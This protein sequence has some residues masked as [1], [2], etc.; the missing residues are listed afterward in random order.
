MGTSR[1]LFITVEVAAMALAAQ[2]CFAQGRV[3]EFLTVKNWHG[4]VNIK[5]SGTGSSS[6]GIFSD[7][8]DYGITTTIDLQLDTYNAN[9]E[10]WTGTFKGNSAINAKDVAT[11][12]GCKQTSTQI[13]QGTFG[14]G[15]K[16][17]MHLQGDNQYVFYP[18]VYS[19]QGATSSVSLDC[20]PGTQ[21]G[22]GPATFSPVLSDKIQTLPATGFNLTGSQKVMMNSPL[23]P[24]S[25]V[26]GGTAA[27][28]EVTIEWN[29]SPGLQT[30]A[31]VVVQ[32][33]TEFQNW[34]PTA[35]SGG[36]RGNSLD[37]IAKLQAKGGGT[38]NVRAAYWIWEFTNC[39]KEP[40]YAMNAPAN[41]PGKD[42]DLKLENL[43]EG[44]L[45]P[46]PTGQRLQSKAGEFTQSTATVA[47]YDWG[48]FGTVKVTAV[49]PDQSQITG[50]LD[51]DSAQT[52]VRLPMR[53]ASSFIPDVWKKSKGVD[54]QADNS[55]T[56][57]DPPGDGNAGDGLT[58]Y[59]EYRGFIIDG[60][61]VEGN[62]KKKD[63]FILNR[64]G[65]F[66]LS[67][68]R[69][70]QNLSGLEVHYK[71]KG[72]EMSSGRAVNF[73]HDAGPH[74]GDQHGVIVVPIAANAGYAEAQGGP[75]TPRSITQIVAPR[76][77]P[78]AES[79]Y[80]DYMGSTLAHELFH[81]ANVYHHGDGPSKYGV[82][83]WDAAAGTALFYGLPAKVL[84][85]S[86]EDFPLPDTSV[87][88][89]LGVPGDT[90]GGDD[91]CVMRYD[92]A[93]GYFSKADPKAIYLVDS[94]PAGFALCSQ[95]AGTGINASGRLPQSR[96]GDAAQGRGNCRA[97]ILVN[98]NV[99]APKR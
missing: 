84:S 42:F 90:H 3:S 44:V 81:A 39:S 31:E 4:T 76:L 58:L 51:G 16:F 29:I 53:V 35:A 15:M 99:A 97:Q 8:W 93:R 79:T 78:D 1:S 30:D 9:I 6:G 68:F 32:K 77:L 67:G 45:V 54:G 36:G 48:G 94:E 12:S 13:F 85:E 17:T 74:N 33:T 71:L 43:A 47:S 69:L 52:E 59:E 2:A 46:D 23:Q 25:L 26:F 75:G 40:G 63:Y 34:R 27:A 80:I 37:L 19:V 91:S 21:G 14:D 87:T 24:S 7:I 65:A 95:G 96:Y 72:S 20:A 22:T 70:F 38:T 56:E 64:A 28:I 10:G 82:V 60:Q 92:D 73:N 55:D 98:D 89:V 11:F 61:H 57:S 18:S 41:N 5:G 50:Y 88:Y 49:M 66:Y 86:G 83:R 62:P